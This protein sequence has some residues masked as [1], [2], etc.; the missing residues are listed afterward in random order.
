[1]ASA[2]QWKT[3]WLRFG[4]K[5]GDTVH[6]VYILIHNLAPVGCQPITC[7]WGSGR[8]SINMHHSTWIFIVIHLSFIE[9]YLFLIRVTVC[10]KPIPAVSRCE[11]TN[12]MYSHKLPRKTTKSMQD[13]MNQTWP[14]THG[15]PAPESSLT[16]HDVVR[17]HHLSV[18]IGQN[19]PVT[20]ER[21]HNTGQHWEP[22]ARSH[23]S[24]HLACW[25]C[26]NSTRE[27]LKVINNLL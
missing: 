7:I 11:Q 5:G 10:V 4:A 20:P 25:L 6:I 9:S 19:P 21:A 17:L 18:G 2:L 24:C 1:M 22:R 15:A 16:L 8:D 26:K 14:Y 12:R 23:G 3:S 27:L 13:I